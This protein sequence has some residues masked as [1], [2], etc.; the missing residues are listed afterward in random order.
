MKIYRQR[1]KIRQWFYLH[2]DLILIPLMLFGAFGT[3]ILLMYIVY[4]YF[5]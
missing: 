2:E 1:G 5:N 3:P 4:W